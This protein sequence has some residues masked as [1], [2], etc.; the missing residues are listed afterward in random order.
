MPRRIPFDAAWGFDSQG[1][2]YVGHADASSF[3][4]IEGDTLSLDYDDETP[5]HQCHPHLYQHHHPSDQ[6]YFDPLPPLEMAPSFD[7]L[8]PAD[9]TA[10]DMGDNVSTMSGATGLASHGLWS[11]PLP[12]MSKSMSSVGGTGDHCRRAEVEFHEITSTS[13][14]SV[15]VPNEEADLPSF[16]SRGTTAMMIFMRRSEETRMEIIENL[17]S[18]PIDSAVAL[19]TNIK[20]FFK[21]KDSRERLMSCFERGSRMH[22]GSSSGDHKKRRFDP[23]VSKSGSD[24]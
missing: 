10:S 15:E 22:D 14:H 3:H 9:D 5:H 24:L 23:I 20:H 8:R 12:V 11:V 2:Y 4:V 21:T 7:V 1:D 6:R 13:S 18:M 17:R 19:D 16:G